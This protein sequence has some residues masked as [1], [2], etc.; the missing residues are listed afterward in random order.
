M[1]LKIENYI[2]VLEI[3]IPGKWAEKVQLEDRY[4]PLDPYEIHQ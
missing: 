2:P 3:I 4:Q 1:H